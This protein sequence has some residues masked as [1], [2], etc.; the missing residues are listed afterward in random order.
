MRVS[1]RGVWEC[2][3]I[4]VCEAAHRTTEERTGERQRGEET[5]R[6]GTGE[7]RERKERGTREREEWRTGL[8]P[9]SYPSFARHY[10]ER[11][12]GI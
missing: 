11:C 8:V 10:A 9:H 1:D 5:K 2:A 3:W 4:C 12:T 7:E 6:E